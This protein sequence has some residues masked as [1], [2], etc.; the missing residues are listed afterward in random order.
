MLTYLGAGERRYGEEGIRM[1]ARPYWEF[2]AV[3]SGSI[4]PTIP[5]ASPQPD[6]NKEPTLWVFPPGHVHGWSAARH[7]VSAISVFHFDSISESAS[8]FIR[9]AGILKVAPKKKD[10]E[11]I[12][13]LAEE[14]AHIRNGEDTLAFFKF[15]KACL[16]L[17]II[18]LEALGPVSTAPLLD[19]AELAASGA[20]AWYSEHMGESPSIEMAASK[21]N[22]SVSHFRRLFIKARSEAP[23]TAFAELRLNR[24]REL[25]RRG[26]VSIK[27][28]SA[29]CGYESQ[30]CFSRSFKKA[31]GLPPSAAEFSGQAPKENT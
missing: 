1:Y 17:T 6:E 21:M 19:R 5:G 9:K 18:A 8:S 7:S 30:S 28:I 16:E 22:C 20:L 4:F 3:H 26:N 15:E 2:Q 23:K 27:E 13:R 31:T 12:A 14:M 29:L 25:L 11:R 24:A 10:M